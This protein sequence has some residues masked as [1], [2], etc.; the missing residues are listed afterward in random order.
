V[1]QLPGGQLAVSAPNLPRHE[2]FALYAGQLPNEKAN[3]M[4]RKLCGYFW[5]SLY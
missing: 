4:L 3:G 1:V 2:S 5:F